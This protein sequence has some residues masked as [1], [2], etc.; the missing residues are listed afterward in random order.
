M[1][2]VGISVDIPS[3]S[4]NLKKKLEL[5]YPL[6]RDPEA[7]V[8]DAYGVAMKDMPLAIPAVFLVDPSGAIL[9]KHVGETVPDRPEVEQI[10][11][12]IDGKRGR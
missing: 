12:A 1:Q 11:E 10:L 8:A 2:V 6:L 7:R 5:P 3:A 9:W 4:R